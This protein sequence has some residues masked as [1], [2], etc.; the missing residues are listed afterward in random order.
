MDPRRSERISEAMREELDEMIAYELADPRVEGASVAEVLI[1]PDARH[2]RIRVLVE[3]T[4]DKQRD[5]IEALNGARNYLR[6]ELSHRL[7][8]FRIPDL[9]FESAL[10][11]EFGPR[12]KHLL[13]RMKRGR[14]R[15]D[16]ATEKF[17]VD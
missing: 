5:V 2:A 12:M 14:P 1:S 7:D 8:V 11:G 3:G 16:G 9:H 10:G 17:P 4:E 15:P 6:R 13:K